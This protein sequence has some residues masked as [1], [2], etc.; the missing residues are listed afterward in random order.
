MET[1]MALLGTG[2]TGTILTVLY[3][4]YKAFNHKRCRSNCCGKKLE[5]SLDMENTSPPENKNQHFQTDNPIV[6]VPS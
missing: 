1:N 2:T 6:K 5:L 3:L 4:L